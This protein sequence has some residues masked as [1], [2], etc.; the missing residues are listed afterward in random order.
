MNGLKA[1][2]SVCYNNGGVTRAYLRYL[3]TSACFTFCDERFIICQVCELSD[4]ERA[5]CD[6]GGGYVMV[7]ELL[8]LISK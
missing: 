7:T 4:S 1:A 5:V 8:Y 6:S 3:G 2:R